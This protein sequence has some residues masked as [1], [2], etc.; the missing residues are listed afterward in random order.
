M[1]YQWKS[2]AQIKADAQVAGAL[3]ERLETNGGLTA[4]RLVDE[5]RP[6]DAPLHSEFEWD[7][8]V[9]AEAYREEQASHIIRSLVIKPEEQSAEPIRAFFRTTEK[10]TYESISVVLNDT[11]KMDTLLDAAM[12]DLR[13]FQSKYSALKSLIPVMDAIEEFLSA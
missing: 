10:K 4:R 8:A 2:A 7:D 11:R 13:A 3:F 6:E 5:S 9:A 12:K 1:V